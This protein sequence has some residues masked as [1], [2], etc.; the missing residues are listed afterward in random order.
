MDYI[1]PLLV[2]IAVNLGA[3][4]MILQTLEDFYEYR[5]HCRRIA[6]IPDKGVVA[7]YMTTVTL[8]LVFVINLSAVVL[9]F[10][11]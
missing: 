1:L 9:T 8:T 10:T 11:M 7:G 5:E 3:P 4:F 6:M 2:L